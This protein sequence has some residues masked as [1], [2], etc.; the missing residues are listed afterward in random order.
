MIPMFGS[1]NGV[2]VSPEILAAMAEANTG[3]AAGYGDDQWT[4][5]LDAAY[6]TFFKKECYVLSAPTGT[7]ANALALSAITPPYGQV[8]CHE[9]AHIFTTE[10]GAPEFYAGG[11]R[12]VPLAGDGGRLS[13]K[14]VADYLAHHFPHNRHHMTMAAISVT[15]PTEVG[16]LYSLD[17]L[18]AIAEVVHSRGM[19]VHMDGARFA[20]ALVAMNCTPAE[21]SWRCGIDILTFG[22]TKN[23]TM[24]AEAI[25]VFDRDLVAE[26]ALRHK[27]A[28]LLTSKMRFASVQL[29]AYLEGDLWRRNALAANGAARSLESMFARL[30]GAELLY[31]VET[32]QVFV[33]LSDDVLA[34]LSSAGCHFRRWGRP[35]PNVH[36]LVTAFSSK[37]DVDD[38]FHR[39]QNSA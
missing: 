38:I 22:T 32:N 13:A 35:R 28:G 12:L 19:K 26:L 34:D 16:T 9:D 27:R 6:S 1:D 30:P 4:G 7:A 39:I 23:G 37:A 17:E 5:R 20:N 29:L 14:S 24:N 21:L 3:F 18:A 2:G 25:I 36:R 10:C 8:L 31:P 15:Q 11:S 33:S